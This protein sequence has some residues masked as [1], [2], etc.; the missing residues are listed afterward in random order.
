MEDNFLVPTFKQASPNE[1]YNSIFHSMLFFV[2]KY[3]R[4][5]IDRAMINDTKQ[6][7]LELD[8]SNL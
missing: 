1:R 2:I 8:K 3:C 4:S 7:E 5:L 6:L